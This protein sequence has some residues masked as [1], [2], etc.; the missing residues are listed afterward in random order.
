MAPFDRPYTTFYCVA[1]VNVALSCTV[2]ELFDLN[3]IV[4]FKSGLEVT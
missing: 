1:I 3:N 4:T 2:F